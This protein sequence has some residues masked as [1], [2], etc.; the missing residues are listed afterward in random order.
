MNG[1]T[2]VLIAAGL[3]ARYSQDGE[4]DLNAYLDGRLELATVIGSFRLADQAADDVERGV[5]AARAD[6][7]RRKTQIE[8][9]A[10]ERSKRPPADPPRWVG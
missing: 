1:W 10:D 2:D 7:R 6:I 4:S 5:A 9:L 3:A 8:N